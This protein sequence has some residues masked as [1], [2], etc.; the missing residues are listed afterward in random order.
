MITLL[1]SLGDHALSLDPRD[2]YVL[3]QQH[4]LTEHPPEEAGDLISEL[5]DGGMTPADLLDSYEE[6]AG[7]DGEASLEEAVQGA[8]R[9][10]RARQVALEEAAIVDDRRSSAP[11]DQREAEPLVMGDE[12]DA[13]DAL[14]LLD[15]PVWCSDD[16]EAVQ[17]LIAS[18][19][20]K[21]WNHAYRDEDAAV[22]QVEASVGGPWVERIRSEFLTT[23]RAARQVQMPNN[24]RSEMY[25]RL[26]QLRVV[27]EAINRR[28]LLVLSGMGTG[29]TLAAMLATRIDNAQRV[30][31]VTPNNAVEQW[32]R[33][34]RGSW[35]GIEVQAK[36]GNRVPQWQTSGPQYLVT[37]FEA[38]SYMSDG[39]MA[40][41]LEHFNIDAVI[42]DEVQFAK[43]RSSDTQS[44]R[45][46]Q[47]TRLIAAA[48]ERCPDLMVLGMSGTP[49]LNE[50]REGQKLIEMVFSEDRADLP[51]ETTRHAAMRM[52]R[53]MM[54]LGVRQRS[55]DLWP[56]KI[57][58]VPVEASAY[59]DDI[60]AL[61]RRRA[62][63]SS[64]EQ[65]LVQAKLPIIVK[66]VDGPTLVVTQFVEG[67]VEPLRQALVSRGL[68]VGV[69]T[70]ENKLATTDGYSSSLD[71]FIDGATDV[72]I[73]SADCLGTGI[74]GLQGR[75][76]RMVFATL[77]WTDGALAQIV[78]RLARHGQGHPV[79]VVAPVTTIEYV[80][81][82]GPQVFSFCSWRWGTI[83][84]KRALALAAV[85]GT[86]PTT[87][88]ALSPQKAQGYI[89]EWID[90][91][92]KGQA[93][94]RRQ[95]P[96]RVPL[97]FT[98]HEDELSARR[99]FGD[100]AACHSR[101][102]AAVSSRTH[103]RLQANPQEWELY[104]TDLAAT[105]LAWQVH[106]L[107]E[108]TRHCSRS[109]GLV[110]GAF[111][112]G[113]AGL[114]EALRGRHVVHSFDHLAIS[115][116]VVACDMGN[117]VPLEDAS[118]DLAVFNLSLMGRNWRDYLT[119]AWRCLKPTGQLLTW[120]PTGWAEDHRL[121]KA[122]ERAGFQTISTETRWKWQRIW[123]V[124]LQEVPIQ[125]QRGEG[126]SPGSGDD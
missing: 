2:L 8:H 72:L 67:I 47:I 123:A 113:T 100:L 116:A 90:R 101:W 119:E 109:I 89:S 36:P 78:A 71:E 104:H 6:V 1:R 50:L 103:Q 86:L 74:D 96:I 63:I 61:R 76:H 17:A 88:A 117:G 5:L 62:T 21:I 95:R 52:F 120:M 80:S 60:R 59:L 118:L 68:R 81:S 77:P 75:C 56:I 18:A 46:R 102:N 38:F 92:E 107:E 114:A 105:R 32:T 64:Y 12:V 4:K 44:R 14:S 99:S 79:D 3:F 51:V 84:S 15:H 33:A 125:Q 24:Y 7:R 28:R 27:V 40:E 10:K 83:A 26:M 22:A 115:Q 41:L 126:A 30:L 23:Y 98:E 112:C 49:I 87:D 29:K 97:V 122:I 58:R 91:L 65:V 110:I 48:G 42:V 19:M 121:D 20:D 25:P 39:A 53:E 73:G 57:S 45:R 31:V 66:A 43:Q 94:L 70:G 85:D 11:S 93:Q 16:E 54:R 35:A 108:T 124:V 111:G 9:A 34:L 106:A 55:A 37:N 69:F 82:S 13:A